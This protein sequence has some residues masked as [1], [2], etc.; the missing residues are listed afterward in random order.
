MAHIFFIDPIEKLTIAKDS[1]LMLALALQE[2]GEEVRLLFEKDFYFSS[3]R[4]CLSCSLF[5]FLG[6]WD[7]DGFYLKHFSL[8]KEERRVLQASDTLH[9]RLEP[10]FDKRYLNYLW[11]LQGV[12]KGTGVNIINSPEGLLLYNEKIYAYQLADSV[13]S[14]VG[15]ASREFSIFVGELKGRGVE[16]VVLKPLDLYQG[17]GVEKISLTHPALIKK[18]EQ[19][20]HD[21]QGAIVAQPFLSQIHEGEIRSVFFYGEELG[22]ILKVPPEGG[23]LSTVARGADC[24]PVTLTL[25]QRRVCEEV[26]GK[27]QGFGIHWIA[28][29]ILGDSIQEVN[30]TCPG[31]LGE[32]S[33]IKGERLVEKMLTPLVL[34]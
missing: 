10:P 23:F 29:D 7:S 4:E 25:K 9:M 20:V 22:S 27:L 34:G 15:S 12:Q 13:D 28:F 8:Q 21:S 14:F 26:A 1:S 18:F 33:R 16:E 3:R 24:Y 11:M 30:I 2:V 17:E 32:V 5:T 6:E 19:K 31:L